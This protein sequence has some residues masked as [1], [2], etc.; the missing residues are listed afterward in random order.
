MFGP[1]ERYPDSQPIHFTRPGAPPMLLMHGLADR[2]VRPKNSIN[3][4]AALQAQGV[5]VTL[6]TYPR[7]G[8]GDTVAA[9]SIPAR[10]RAPTL[11][12]IAAFMQLSLPPSS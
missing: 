2:S 9:L 7:L 4:A 5:A 10:R 11:A 3:L 12:E 1:P 6:K 8:H